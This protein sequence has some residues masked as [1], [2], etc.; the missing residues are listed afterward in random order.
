[1]GIDY[2][3]T[4]DP[5]VLHLDLPRLDSTIKIRIRN[6]IETKLVINPTIYGLPLRGKLGG[7]WKLRIGDYRV[8]YS[9]I[10]NEI[11]IFCIGHRSD[12]YKMM[13]KRI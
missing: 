11:R 10:K 5:L 1:M 7:Y 12:V 6:S 4:Y 9:V 13:S 3:L 2:Y 8:V